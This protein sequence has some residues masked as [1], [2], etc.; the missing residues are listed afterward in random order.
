MCAVDVRG[1]EQRENGNHERFV[2]G[3][4][5]SADKHP[6][7]DRLQ[8]CKVDVGESEPAQIVCGAWNFGGGGGVI[9]EL[10]AARRKTRACSSTCSPPIVNVIEALTAIATLS[11][12]PPA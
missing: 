12:Q 10:P 3:H 1:E 5:L 11:D 6:N 7:A 8:L 4:V 2:V 9:S